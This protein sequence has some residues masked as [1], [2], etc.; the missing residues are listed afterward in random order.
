V[1]S[2]L[3]SRKK[4]LLFERSYAAPVDA[5]WGAWT[6][7]DRL[8]AWWGPDKTTV[9]DC[10]VDLRLGGRLYIVTVASEAMGKYAGTR[11]PM[12]G[13]F[14]R[15][16]E[17]QRL[18]YDARSW[19]EGAEATETIHHTNDLTL[20]DD[21]EKTSLTLHVVITEIRSGPKAKLAVFGMKWGYK[22]QLD[23]LDKYLAG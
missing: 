7:A 2:Q 15:I 1:I 16:D 5:V 20:T 23:A 9:A 11:W 13:T 10:E 12:E 14:T 8:R 21:G 18:I 3:L 19:T 4:E 17:R 22:S 6:E